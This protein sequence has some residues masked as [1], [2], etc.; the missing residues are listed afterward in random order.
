MRYIP[1]VASSTTTQV[2]ESNNAYIN[3]RNFGALGL[4]EVEFEGTLSSVSDDTVIISS[5]QD[6]NAKPLSQYST[7]LKPGVEVYAFIHSA[8]PPPPGPIEY[9]FSDVNAP[10]LGTLPS[11]YNPLLTISQVIKEPAGIDLSG[12][13]GTLPTLKPLKYYIWGLDVEL[14]RIDR[15]QVVII[16]SK[17]LDPNLWGVDTYIELR[18]T[19]SSVNVLPLIYRSW[20]STLDFLGVIGNAKVGFAG[21]GTIA[22]KDEGDLEIP[23][24]VPNSPSMP[25]FI[26]DFFSNVA[27]VPTL[28]KALLGKELFEIPSGAI[29]GSNNLQ[30][31][32]SS[33]SPISTSFS[34]QYNPN[35]RIRFVVDDTKPIRNAIELAATSSVKELYFPSGTYFLRDTSVTN[36]LSKNYSSVSFRGV[37]ASSKIKR[38]PAF[39]PSSSQPG[40]LSFSGLLPNAPLEGT[41]FRNISIDGNSSS[42]FSLTSPTSLFQ[43]NEPSIS[44]ENASNI[45]ITELKTENSGGNG[46][47]IKNSSNLLISNSIF[48]VSGR[49]YELGISPMYLYTSQNVVA[50]GNIFEFATEGPLLYSTDF[51]SINNNIVRSCGDRGILIEASSQWN[52]LNN[53]AYSDNGSLII[54]VDQYTPEFFG[55]SIEVTR[56]IALSPIYFTVTDGGESV[57]IAKSTISAK[58]FA[59]DSNGDFESVE[60]GTFKVT[61]TSDQLEVGIFSITLPGSGAQIGTILPT[62]S[63]DLLNPSQANYGYGYQ[64][65]ATVRIGRGGRGFAPLSIRG[66]DPASPGGPRRIAIRLRNSSDL[67]ALQVYSATSPENDKIIIRDFLNTIA[68]WEEN[69]GYS[70]VGIDA[71]SNSLLLNDIP[72]LTGLSSEIEFDEGELFIQRS[73]Y[74]VSKGNIT[75]N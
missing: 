46:L 10:V 21:A 29:V 40:L 56:G 27:G 53:L 32:R 8:T 64:I 38:V 35:N 39:I 63:F 2:S 50:Q 7:E 5:V 25:S 19:R 42:N 75:V 31:K 49:R 57:S 9:D 58:I 6:Q 33:N 3:M 34:G 28:T 73:N 47:F 60:L 55:P 36:T 41:R 26:R 15:G 4:G 65:T 24:W 67:L 52:A 62:S 43:S 54:S 22:F 20:G 30:L 14:G 13:S 11:G 48:S 16:G 69:T 45:Y 61:E 70:V 66:F 74:L 12:S 51:S 23:S 37:G 1:N 71:D 59:L 18:F 17:V 44:I 68:G 72:A